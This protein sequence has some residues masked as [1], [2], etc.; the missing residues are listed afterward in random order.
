MQT[1]QGGSNEPP[2]ILHLAAA[3]AFSF[4]KT[5]FILTRMTGGGGIIKMNFCNPYAKS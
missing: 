3:G 1:T 2:C 5:N 4:G